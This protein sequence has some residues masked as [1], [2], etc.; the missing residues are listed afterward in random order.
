VTVTKPVGE[1]DR[2]YGS[3][4]AKDVAKGL[5]DEGVAGVDKKKIFMH[6]AIRQLG[7]Y[8]VPIKLTGETT[9]NIKV[10]VVAK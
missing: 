9:V 3:V 7:I 1:G 10:W 4:T 5:T 2:L 6:E 8:D